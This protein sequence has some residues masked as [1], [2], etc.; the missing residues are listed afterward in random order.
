MPDRREIPK[1]RTPPRPEK[2]EVS[3]STVG[4]RK[5]ASILVGG[6]VVECPVC[7]AVVVSLTKH[8][9]VLHPSERPAPTPPPQ[10]GGSKT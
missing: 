9:D 2:V 10:A 6:T 8:T 5:D 3:E 4:K 7:S 1:D